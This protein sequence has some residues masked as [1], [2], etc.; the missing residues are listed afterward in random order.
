MTISVNQVVSN[1]VAGSSST[2]T[3]S[4]SNTQAGAL[5]DVYVGFINN[6]IIDSI[7]DTQ[8]N[9][10]TQI[11]SPIDMTAAGYKMAHYYAQNIVGGSSA[12]TITVTLH[13]AE[14]SKSVHVK[15]IRGG[16]IS[17]NPDTSAGQ[18]QTSPT[19]STDALTSGTATSTGQPA[20][21]SGMSVEVTNTANT[22]A[23]GTGFSSDATA[24]NTFASVWAWRME[25]NRVTS[26]GSQAAT[27]TAHANTLHGT[28][29]AVFDEIPAVNYT[30]TA[31]QGTFSLF[32]SQGSIDDAVAAQEGSF[33]I[34]GFTTTGQFSR[35]ISAARGV[36]GL[37]GHPATLTYHDITPQYVLLNDAVTLA[38]QAGLMTVPPY[39][40]A[41]SLTVPYGYVI[42]QSPAAGVSV[43]LGT[44]VT[45]IVSAGYPNPPGPT[46]AVQNVL[47]MRILDAEAYIEDNGCNVNPIYKFQYSNT[48]PQGT[49]MAQSPAPGGPVPAGTIVTLTVS[50]GIQINYIGSTSVIVPVM[51]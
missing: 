45:L 4:I 35:G 44:R 33:S 46:P 8:G 5:F 27:F 36:F 30:L 18:T 47:G 15:E 25:S 43:P 22:P 6:N 14:T 40:I 21:I 2:V 10:Y 49:V 11:G 3:V 37:S 17:G 26:T 23:A 38:V 48:Y 39:P 13:F 50:L 41:Y 7:T 12:N 20:L 29:M 31:A 1:S 16:V 28:M 51:H 19:T 32:G 9:T 34:T 24:T 42:A